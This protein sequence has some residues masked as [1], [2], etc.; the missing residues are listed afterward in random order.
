MQNSG[1]GNAINPLLSLI[2]P[3]V[4]RIPL[5]LLIGW[6][7]EPAFH[8]EPQHVKQGK[9]TLAL[10]EAAGIPHAVLSDDPE[11]VSRQLD[12]CFDYAAKNGAPYALV[13]RKN[14][15]SSNY[16]YESGAAAEPLELSREAAIEAVLLSSGAAEF[17]VS[18][19][20]MAS[21][22][23]YELREKHG[24]GHN[25][26]FLTV[27]SMGHASSIALSLALQKPETPVTCLDGDGAA[28]M[29]LGALA[30]IGERKPR[31]LRHI[32]LNNASHDSVGGQPTIAR[33]ID[34]PTIARAC[35][36]AQVYTALNRTELEL[37]L[38]SPREGPV[39][40]EVQ[41][42]KGARGDLGRPGASPEE[43]K[44]AFMITSQEEGGS[45]PLRPGQGPVLP[46]Q[47]GLTAPVT[48]PDIPLKKAKGPK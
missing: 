42:R 18:T 34:L 11:E 22:E 47:R 1:L 28:L 39:F 32:V 21:R 2:D 25:R 33:A 5:I 9:V 23:L 10:L 29:H 41:V 26:D 45:L 48:P 6:R 17:Y 15:F 44:K 40:I 19:T 3:E 13:V 43:N 4:Y 20:G 38:A 37:A 8:D 35:G 14:T 24:R 30:A 7:G 12:A 31:N 36:Y 46:S 27:G 16:D